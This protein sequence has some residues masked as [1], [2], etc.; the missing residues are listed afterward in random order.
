MEKRFIQKTAKAEAMERMEDMKQIEN[1]TIECWE[2][3]IQHTTME[4]GLKR[5][6]MAIVK[7]FIKGL[8]N[9]ET[10]KA[11]ARISNRP[12]EDIVKRA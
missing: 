11:T 9:E 2:D 7:A 6:E 10:Q 1:E 5:T 8:R 3:R 4:A 12:W